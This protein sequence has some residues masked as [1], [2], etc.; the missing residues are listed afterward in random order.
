MSDSG[1]MKRREFLRRYGIASSAL[2]LSPFFLDRFASVCSAATPLTRVYKASNGDCFQNVAKVLDMLGG[3]GK[4]IS[5]TD[6]VVIKAN[7][8]WPNQGYTH[9]GCLKAVVDAILAIPGF[10]GEVLICDNTQTWSAPGAMG[11]DAT[12]ANRG[13]NWP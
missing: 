6:V 3:I 7:A 10:S 8:Q 13:H 5:P 9:T 1:A 2:T 12:P 4:Y 11:F